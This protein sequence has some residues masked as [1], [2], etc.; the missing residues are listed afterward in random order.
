MPEKLGLRSAVAMEEQ[1]HCRL[2]SARNE[3]G[4]QRRSRAFSGHDVG[5]KAQADVKGISFVARPGERDSRERDAHPVRSRE[6]VR[7]EARDVART[8]MREAP[9]VPEREGVERHGQAR[10]HDA[11][12]SEDRPH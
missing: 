2:I 5:L 7:I 6:P 3:P 11:G 8:K 10:R 4:L 12:P 9:G 1:G